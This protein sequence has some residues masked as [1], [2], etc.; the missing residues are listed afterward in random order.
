MAFG[1][2]DVF[3]AAARGVQEYFV[4]LFSEFVGKGLDG[5]VESDNLGKAE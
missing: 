1:I 3:F 4:K 2:E 5:G